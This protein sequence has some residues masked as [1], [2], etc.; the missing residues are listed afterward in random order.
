MRRLLTLT[1]ALALGVPL[2]CDDSPAADGSDT[3]SGHADTLT[4][5][6][7]GDT[8]LGA[9]SLA[10][11]ATFPNAARTGQNHLRLTLEDGAGL[12]LSGATIAVVPTMPMHGH[13]STET[14]IVTDLGGGEYDAFPVTFQMP[15]LWKVA[16]DATLGESSTHLDL[17]VTVP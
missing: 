6:V 11:A 7:P 15:G 5:T 2:G 3:T 16:I 12:G 10:L 9:A 17:N 4:D 8:D 14:A 1:S 13:G